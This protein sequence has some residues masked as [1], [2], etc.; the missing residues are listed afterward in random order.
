MGGVERLVFGGDA[1][2]DAVRPREGSE[3]LDD[4][5]RQIANAEDEL[6]R[7]PTDDELQTIV[8][9]H[10]TAHENS[11]VHACARVYVCTRTRKQEGWVTEL[12]P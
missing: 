8:P 3:A 4:M 11:H 6:R 1:T 7:H 2:I 9:A 10:P 12:R 5:V